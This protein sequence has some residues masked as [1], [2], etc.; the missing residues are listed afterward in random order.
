MH[1]PDGFLSPQTAG[2]MYVLSIPFLIRSASKVKL[3]VQDKTVP[4]IAL[5]SAMCFGIMMINVPLPGGTTGH[6]VGAV[7]ASI[8]AG[9]EQAILAISV[10]LTI[11]ALFFGDGGVLSLGANIFNMAIVMPLAG[12]YIYYFFTRKTVNLRIK[13]ISAFIAGYIAINLAAL[14][15]GIELGIQPLLFHDKAGQ[16]MYFPFG[17]NIAIPAMMLGHLTIAGIAEG[18]LT[19]LTVNWLQ[20]TNPHKM[21]SLENTINDRHFFKWAW[22]A[23]G[24]LLLLTPLGLLAPGTAWGEWSRAELLN[25]GLG[26]VPKGFDTWSNIWHAPIVGYGFSSKSSLEYF[27][28]GTIGIVLS[29]GAVYVIFYFLNKLLGNRRV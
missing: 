15:T 14:L 2:T 24:I 10:T 12:Y 18:T 29:V 4:M 16:A 9:P 11:Q 23:V 22:F 5:S 26:F 25:L 7:I 3:A 13:I 6:A 27:L 20:K 17:L 19:A 21:N 8:L 1:I 28:A